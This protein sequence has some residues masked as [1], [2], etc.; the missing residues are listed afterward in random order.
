VPSLK[1][2]GH[3]VRFAQWS[4]L[5][6]P[7]E[8]PTTSFQAPRRGRAGRRRPDG[9]QVIAKAGSP[10]EYLDAP[11]FQTYWD[12]DAAQMT[13]AVRASARSSD[14]RARGRSMLADDASIRRWSWLHS[15]LRWWSLRQAS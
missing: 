4:A 3:P 2:L 8:L 14:L 13:K 15:R 6:V 11:E 9:R 5:F 1:Q 10:V 12:A 7:A